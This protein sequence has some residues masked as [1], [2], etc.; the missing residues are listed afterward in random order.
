MKFQPRKRFSIS[1]VL[2]SLLLFEVNVGGNEKSQIMADSLLAASL[3]TFLHSRIVYD[4]CE[5]KIPS[6]KSINFI[7]TSY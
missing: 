1:H 5:G 4:H 6:N 7:D 3:L 2:K